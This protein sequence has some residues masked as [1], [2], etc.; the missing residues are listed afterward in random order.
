MFDEKKFIA[1][2][3]REIAGLV[4]MIVATGKD[5][6]A[7]GGCADGIIRAK[8]YLKELGGGTI[9]L[10]GNGASASI[11]SHMATD[12]WKHGGVRAQAF[13]DASLLTCVSNDFSYED[14]FKIPVEMFADAGDVLVCISSSGKSANILRAADVGTAKGCRV[15]TLTGFD[16]GNPL[17]KKGD[18]NFYVPSPKYGPVEIHHTYI[19]HCLSDL[20]VAER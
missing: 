11:A 6:E 7:I 19:L 16:E 2:Y 8:A 12:F 5:G 13:N 18:V 20:I 17:R 3:E 10:V 4:S 14:V 1:D 15:L 9:M